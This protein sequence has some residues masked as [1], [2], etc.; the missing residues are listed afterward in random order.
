MAG[1]ADT[2]VP[3]GTSRR[4]EVLMSD[5]GTERQPDRP[6]HTAADVASDHRVLRQLPE[7]LL[8]DIPLL[9]QGLRLERRA[10]YID[11]H[12]PGRADFRAEGTE[13][14]KPGQHIVARTAVT[15]EAWNELRG[16]C[17]RVVRRPG[18]RGPRSANEVS[19][20]PAA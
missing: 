2:R 11:L 20:R 12:D 13:V 8:G 6:H 7:A 18:G 17:E 16:A 1:Y 15:A 4:W 19:V 3:R 14:V 9:D 10:E 5:E